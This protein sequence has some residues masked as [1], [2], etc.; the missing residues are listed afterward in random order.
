ML[1]A[2]GRRY[3][4]GSSSNT[5]LTTLKE[6]PLSHLTADLRGLAAP[7]RRDAGLLRG[8][9]IAASSAAGLAIVSGPTVRDG[10][11]GLAAALL[12]ERGH[13]TI[14]T[15][16]DAGVLVLD[17]LAPAAQDSRRAL[18]VFTRRLGAETVTS[19]LRDRG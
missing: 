11:E 13:V 2:K 5:T 17:V 4:G 10:P 19:D 8:L 15:F 7:A 6:V 3:P 18:D 14:H 9:L 1:R 16:A 12:L